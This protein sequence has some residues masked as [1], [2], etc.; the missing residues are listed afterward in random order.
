M[1]LLKKI[2]ST[3]SSHEETKTKTKDL[4][5]PQ[6]VGAGGNQRKGS[7]QQ[8]RFKITLGHDDEEQKIEWFDDPEKFRHKCKHVANCIRAASGK[9]VI[10]TGAGISTS[11]KL[12]DY[13]GSDGMWTHKDAGTAMDTSKY[14]KTISSA[15]PTMS[16]MAIATLLEKGL[17]A[18]V[19]S[20]N[21]DGLHMRSGIDSSHLAELHGNSYLEI[22]QSCGARYMRDQDILQGQTEEHRIVNR[23]W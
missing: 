12:P 10:Y 21:V 11:A 18:S 17:V 4:K 8:G 13:R 19:V 1:N 6:V 16:H 7:K 14:V 2:T 23:H 5:V 22:C 15:L 20:T 9:V 3:S